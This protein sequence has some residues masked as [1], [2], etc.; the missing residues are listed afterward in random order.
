MEDRGG[1]EGG[2]AFCGLPF[3]PLGYDDKKK[4][5]SLASPE[6]E[7]GGKGAGKYEEAGRWEGEEETATLY[8]FVFARQKRW[9]TQT[10]KQAEGGRRRGRRRRPFNH[11]AVT[12]AE[13]EEEREGGVFDI[14]RLPLFLLF[15]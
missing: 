13:A 8:F 5:E 4:N 9:E 15:V 11:A 7:R 6:G 1:R 2:G 10:S 14:P 3:F 12:Q